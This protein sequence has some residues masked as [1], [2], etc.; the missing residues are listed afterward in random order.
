MRVGDDMYF[1]P[2]H[3]AIGFARAA[4]ANGAKLMPQTTVTRVII[5]AGKVTGVDTD[6]VQFTPRSSSM[7]RA[8][9][10]GRSRKP[11]EYV[12]LSFLG[13]GAC[14]MVATQTRARGRGIVG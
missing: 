11:A 8:P 1:D 9:G 3:V 13:H 2:K 7:L 12:F 5:E 10:Q 4:A 14:R 6:R